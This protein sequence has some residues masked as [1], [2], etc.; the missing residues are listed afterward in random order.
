[1]LN[2]VTIQKLL[3]MRLSAMAEQFRQQMLDHSFHSLSFEDRFGLLT[4][5]EWSRRKNNR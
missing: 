3:E 1:M 2:E 4:D 5:A